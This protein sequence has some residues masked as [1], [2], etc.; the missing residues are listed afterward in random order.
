ML[1]HEGTDLGDEENCVLEFNVQ[2][3]RRKVGLDCSMLK[4][5]LKVCWRDVGTKM[6]AE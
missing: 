3:P 1:L 6:V 2:P 5:M 4:G